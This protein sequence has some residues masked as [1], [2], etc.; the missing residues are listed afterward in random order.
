MP[1]TAP[2]AACP[3]NT[4]CASAFRKKPYHNLEELLAD[5]G[6][7]LDQPSFHFKSKDFCPWYGLGLVT[8]RLKSFFSGCQIPPKSILPMRHF[9]LHAF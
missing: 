6:E 4:D 9:D 1:G 5:L 7:W 2:G 8:L 3:A